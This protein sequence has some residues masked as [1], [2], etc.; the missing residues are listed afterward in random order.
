M[1]VVGLVGK[2][3]TFIVTCVVRSPPR[4][5]LQFRSESGDQGSQT[6]SQTSVNLHVAGRYRE[7]QRDDSL[8][9]GLDVGTKHRPESVGDKGQRMQSPDLLQTTS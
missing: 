7:Q 1:T 8:Q 6:P 3:I 5:T 9:S 2:P 4:N